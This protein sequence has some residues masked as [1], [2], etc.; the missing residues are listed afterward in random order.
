[1]ERSNVD[2]SFLE[3]R[4]QA[5]SEGLKEGVRREVRRLRALGL[6]VYVV[7]GDKVIALPPPD[8]PTPHVA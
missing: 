5:I 1:M 4:L 6:P 3:E 8:K 7:D 2:P